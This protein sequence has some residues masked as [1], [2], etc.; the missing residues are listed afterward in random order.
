MGKLQAA[1]AEPAAVSAAALAAI[2][3]G[4]P[5]KQAE[6]AALPPGAESMFMLETISMMGKLVWA[7]V[8][9]FLEPRPQLHLLVAPEGADCPV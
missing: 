1:P 3:C 5:V 4:I 2:P 9:L 8:L 6:P 7:E